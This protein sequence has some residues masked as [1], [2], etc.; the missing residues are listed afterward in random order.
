MHLENKTDARRRTF[1]KSL[2]E[3][4]WPGQHLHHIGAIIVR[5]RL[6]Q[7]YLTENFF[8]KQSKKKRL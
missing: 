8:V 5:D 2:N 6:H 3:R 4:L 7:F 1:N